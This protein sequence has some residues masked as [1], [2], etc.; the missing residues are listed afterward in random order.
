LLVVMV[1]I[2]LLIAILI[3]GVQAAREAARNSAS[4][5]NLRQI[6]LAMANY[7][8]AKSHYPPSWQGVPPASGA[9]NIDGWSIF[10]LLLPY[11]EQQVVE[12]KI[13]Y[14]LSYNDAPNV[15][16]ADGKSVKLSSLRV[17]TYVS[18]AEPRDEVRFAGGAPE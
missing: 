18:P 6:G 2:G 16:T 10:A 3:P 1:I 7:E 17:P 5:N 12:S 14:S 13:D 11:L 15:V 8:A 4:K 9:A